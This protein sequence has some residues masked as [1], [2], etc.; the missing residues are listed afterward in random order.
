MPLKKFS[1][2]IKYLEQCFQ[3]GNFNE[4]K[5]YQK[6]STVTLSEWLGPDSINFFMDL[7]IINHVIHHNTDLKS[8]RKLI[9]KALFPNP[10]ALLKKMAQI[11]VTFEELFYTEAITQLINGGS[12]SKLHD[13]QKYFDKCKNYMNI[14]DAFNLVKLFLDCNLDNGG[15]YYLL[16]Y[17]TTRIYTKNELNNHV[18]EILDVIEKKNPSKILNYNTEDF[19]GMDMLR[20]WISVNK[21][22]KK[23]MLNLGLVDKRFKKKNNFCSIC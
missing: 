21:K 11:P 5:K 19:D 8:S 23:R 1:L 12:P 22:T 6:I 2:D 4:I 17:T 14:G 20:I 16:I 10:Q 3:N 7:D 15:Y 18:N 9:N 13:I